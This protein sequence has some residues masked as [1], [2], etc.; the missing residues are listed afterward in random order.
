MSTH[1]PEVP[2]PPEPPVEPHLIPRASVVKDAQAE[3][4]CQQLGFPGG[5]EVLVAALKDGAGGRR[6]TVQKVHPHAYGGARMWGEAVASLRERA[7]DGWRAGEIGGVEMLVDLLHRR[8]V[9]VTAGNSATGHEQYRPNVR[10]PRGEVV[11]NLV[12]GTSTNETPTLWSLSDDSDGPDWEVW[13]LLH[14]MHKKNLHG[15]LSRVLK[16]SPSG[17][18]SRW[19]LRILLPITE[20]GPDK[21][22]RREPVSPPV[23]EVNVQRRTG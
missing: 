16:I 6:A 9:V 20:F 3:V 18:V 13:M 19:G 22:E 14:H 1:P 12:N 23:V 4:A 10:Y 5:T 2:Q 8:A 11:A 15:E 7:P 17:Y 21:G